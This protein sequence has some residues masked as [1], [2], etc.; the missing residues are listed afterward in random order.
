VALAQSGELVAVTWAQMQTGVES[1][2]GLIAGTSHITFI[3]SLGW[4]ALLLFILSA[5][6]VFV[7][8]VL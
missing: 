6:L 7:K 8:K 4:M 2:A 3:V 5:I 1:A